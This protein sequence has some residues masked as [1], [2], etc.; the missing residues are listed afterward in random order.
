[1]TRFAVHSELVIIFTTAVP[2]TLALSPSRLALFS[3]TLSYTPQ[4]G[5][6]LPSPVE[7]WT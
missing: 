6:R 3:S 2:P 4:P 1:M 7:C 5:A